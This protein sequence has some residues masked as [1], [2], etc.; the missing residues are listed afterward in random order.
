VRCPVAQ[1]MFSRNPAVF[2]DSFLR[3]REVG[4]AKDSSAPL[5]IVLVS[6]TVRVWHTTN[7]SDRSHISDVIL[8]P[9]NGFGRQ[10]RNLLVQKMSGNALK[11]TEGE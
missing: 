11:V 1:L 5:R 9:P 10:G 8:D 2:Q 6:L 3:H 7:L 4:R